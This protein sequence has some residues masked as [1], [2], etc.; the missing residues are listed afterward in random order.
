M[1]VWALSRDLFTC[2]VREF[3]NKPEI[4][5]TTSLS[6]PLSYLG[7]LVGVPGGMTHGEVSKALPVVRLAT[8]KLLLSVDDVVGLEL[9]AKTLA[10]KHMASVP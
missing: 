1:F 4:I 2:V 5:Q 8:H 6:G 10:D 3:L 9:L 7:L